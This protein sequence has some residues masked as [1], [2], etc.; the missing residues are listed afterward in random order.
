MVRLVSI[1]GAVGALALN[2]GPA[3]GQG[4]GPEANVLPAPANPLQGTNSLETLRAFLQLQEQLR[5]AQTAIEQS[6]QELKA[7]E[8]QT[9]DALSNAL[10]A[11]EHTFASQRTHDLETLEASKQLTLTA[12][13]AFAALG[14]LTMLLVSFFQWRMSKGLEDISAAL[15]AVLG[16]GDGWTGPALVPA[17]QPDLRGIGA[18]EQ[19][20]PPGRGPAHGLQSGLKPRG[21]AGSMG[22][23]FFPIPAPPPRKRPVRALRTAII[24]G[25]ICAT[26]LAL[27]FYLVAWQKL[28]LGHVPG[29]FRL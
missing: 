15:P 18:A 4:V 22:I 17:G 16:L 27:L 11:I 14:F 23:R 25:L 12:A 3:W 13:G 28:G 19:S 1:I 9:A 29:M 21:A 26:A 10:Q 2:L 20:E 7:A 24:V 6:R 5:A 8:T